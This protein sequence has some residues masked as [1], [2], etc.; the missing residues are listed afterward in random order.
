[1]SRVL[2]KYNQ[3]LIDLSQDLYDD[4]LVAVFEKYV[5]EVEETLRNASQTLSSK[6]TPSSLAAAVQMMRYSIA[7]AADGLDEM[8]RFCQNYDYDHLHMAANLFRE[9]NDLSRKGAQ[10]TKSGY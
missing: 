3:Q 4:Q 5:D 1:M 9:A 2:K 6:D 8:R 10:L 7:Q